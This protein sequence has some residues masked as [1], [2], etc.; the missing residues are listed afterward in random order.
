MKKLIILG[1]S[2]VIIGNLFVWVNPA[3]A[4]SNW[5][6]TGTTDPIPPLDHSTSKTKRV[7]LGIGHHTSFDGSR[8]DAGVY[9]LD[10]YDANRTITIRG[11]HGPVYLHGDHG[12]P[13][14]DELQCLRPTWGGTIDNNTVYATV[15]L[16]A[17]G[18]TPITYKIKRSNMCNTTPATNLRTNLDNA[19]MFGTYQLPLGKADIDPQT[20]TYRVRVTIEYTGIVKSI[21]SKFFGPSVFFRIAASPATQ[22]RVAALGTTSSTNVHGVGTRTYTND[23]E[24]YTHTAEFGSPCSQTGDVVRRVEIY[25]PDNYYR[26]SGGA[27]IVSGTQ[28]NLLEPERAGP[29]PAR[30]FTFYITENGTR[31]HGSRYTSLSNAVKVGTGTNTAIL[32]TSYI[33]ED[34]GVS[35]PAIVRINMKP[36]AKY[37]LYAENVFAANFLQIKTPTDAIYNAI[38]C[39][40]GTE[41][42]PGVKISPNPVTVGND[43]TAEA[44]IDNNGSVNSGEVDYDYRVW[45][46]KQGNN[47]FNTGDGDVG[48]HYATGSRTVDPDDSYKFSNITRLI[49]DS[50][51]VE[52]CVGLWLTGIDST[53]VVNSPAISCVPIG[54]YP[55]TQISGGDVLSR[56]ASKQVNTMTTNLDNHNYGSW[57]E[58]SIFA[59]GKVSSISA[60][61]LPAYNYSETADT[62]TALTFANTGPLGSFASGND[63]LYGSKLSVNN[64]P[65]QDW[66]KHD[67]GSGGSLS[68]N[69]VSSL[70]EG[71]INV[72]DGDIVITGT[73]ANIT[74]SYVIHAT[75]KV[76][77]NRSIDYSDGPYTSADDLPQMVI[78]ADDLIRIHPNARPTI[79]AWLIAGGKVMTC[80]GNVAS[81]TLPNYYDNLKGTNCY[82]PL[83][84]NGPIQAGSLYLRRTGGAGADGSSVES[85]STPAEIINLRSDAYLWAYGQAGKGQTIRTDSVRERP[86]RF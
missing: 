61:T 42:Q 56:L 38:D 25:D 29:L 35:K 20:N 79:D 43:V 82:Y 10:K 32:P 9:Y 7:Y 84:I 85:R 81:E 27:I 66:D 18:L 37:V 24:Y 5:L 3:A 75:G 57:V 36:N 59:A 33:T 53:T 71:H 67:L 19:R 48:L 15:T 45:L 14:G 4:V 52:V 41:V 78:I 55:Q 77:I 69:S 49:S 70:K 22:A 46:D 11:N 34:E 6:T 64:G 16:A 50:S 86:P 51:M 60:G 47:S 58:Y 21:K 44:W 74:G 62:T 13:T 83:K 23:T 54:R 1:L 17:D 31:L 39:D 8:L 2:A 65:W 12:W 72:Y 28:G 80:G 63:L 73:L 26:M 68:I 40:K 30:P 76:V